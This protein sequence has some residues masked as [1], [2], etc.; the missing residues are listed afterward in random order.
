MR[1]IW[2]Q[3]FKANSINGGAFGVF[4]PAPSGAVPISVGVQGDETVVWFE[5]EDVGTTM[6]GFR[7]YAIGTGHGAVPVGKKFLG[8][9]QQG[10]YVWRVYH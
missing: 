9:V 8:T 10:Q 3:P 6:E 1:R 5:C 4:V 2:K 7:L